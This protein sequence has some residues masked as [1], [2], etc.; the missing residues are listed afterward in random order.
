MKS[1][2]FESS[3]FLAVLLS[4][5]ATAATL[6]VDLNSGNP[7]P[8]YTNCSI[9]ATNIQ[10]AID[11]ATNGDLVLVTNGIY[12]TGGRPVNG[13]ALTNR[14][15]IDKA[16]TVQSVN[17][18][19]GTV[20]QGYQKLGTALGGGSNA[21]RCA[22]LT[23]GAALVGFTL[24]KGATFD[25][26]DALN[27][28]SGGGVWCEPGGAVRKS[29]LRGNSAN[30]DGGG[31]CGGTLYNCELTDNSAAYGGGVY[32]GQLFNCTVV[33]NR[34]TSRSLGAGTAV[35][36]NYNCIVEFN[37]YTFLANYSQ[38]LFY[39]SCTTP[40]PAGGLG[41]LTNSPNFVDLPGGILR[42]QCGSPC[43]DAG[44]NLSA[45]LTD[46]LRGESRPVDGDGD[47]LAQFDMGA[48]ERNPVDDARDIGIR[49][50]FTNF[51]L[52]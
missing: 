6:Y 12:A 10:D 37:N 47:G 29:A 2:N 17:G 44:T 24:A 26:G 52:Y 5:N 1:R 16:L 21:V 30:A 40:M 7:T 34:A 25:S 13:Y 38:S 31:A 39:W 46:D 42:L 22:Y 36:T 11:A 48:Y 18:P 32:G 14:V 49:T 35:C 28:Q 4:F 9:A 27:E 41:N 8:P 3:V 15:V 51:A 19:T 23:N 50:G 33:N 45:L 20:I 43:I